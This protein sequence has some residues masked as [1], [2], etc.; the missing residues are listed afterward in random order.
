MSIV[1]KLGLQTRVTITPTFSANDWQLYTYSVPCDEAAVKL[2]Q[3][4]AEA[5]NAGLT[6]AEVEKRMDV[7][8]FELR[9]FGAADT[10]PRYVL[11]E[12]LDHVFRQ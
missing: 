7:A 9:T 8:M 1:S 12:A 4:L 5:V 11:A 2:N 10:E 3:A 6:R